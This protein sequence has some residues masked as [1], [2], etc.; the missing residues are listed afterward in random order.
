MSLTY[1]LMLS[2]HLRLGLP[3]SPFPSDSLTKILYQILITLMRATCPTL[4]FLPIWWTSEHVVK[5]SLTI[6]RLLLIMQLS[7]PSLLC[8]HIFISNNLSPKILS[9]YVLP[10]MSEIK[11]CHSKE[12]RPVLNGANVFPTS[13][14]RTVSVTKTWRQHFQDEVAA[15]ISRFRTN[16]RIY[17]NPLWRHIRDHPKNVHLQSS[18]KPTWLP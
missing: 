18:L 11:V 7:P 13:Q 4:L 1:L 9:I 2:S 3:S 6:V 5:N 15:T 10:I 17:M 14:V 8:P 16:S 12:L